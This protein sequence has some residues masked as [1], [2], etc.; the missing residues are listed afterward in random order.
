MRMVGGDFKPRVRPSPDR[1]DAVRI[2]RGRF[3]ATQNGEGPSRMSVTNGHDV[4]QT[5]RRDQ[6]AA[7][8]CPGNTALA[9]IP[10]S[11]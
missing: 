11:Q 5:S 3:G 10:G 8:H 7:P 4:T 2:S 1:C 6:T 9:I